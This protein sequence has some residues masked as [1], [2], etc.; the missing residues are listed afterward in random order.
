MPAFV[1]NHRRTIVDEW[2]K[3]HQQR[4]HRWQS[5]L[6]RP[7]VQPWDVI[8]EPPLN[9]KSGDALLASEYREGLDV[10]I[11]RLCQRLFKDCKQRR[12]LKAPDRPAENKE[13]VGFINLY[14]STE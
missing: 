5:V 14:T 7:R 2:F 6:S 9:T 11:E 12:V 1:T 4:C 13:E 8:T 10:Q 3:Q